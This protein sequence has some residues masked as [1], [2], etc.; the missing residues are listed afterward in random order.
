[1]VTV[2]FILKRLLNRT[3]TQLKRIACSRIVQIKRTKENIPLTW[4]I[5]HFSPKADHWSLLHRAN[6]TS[7][8]PIGHPMTHVY[9]VGCVQQSNSCLSAWSAMF[10]ITRTCVA[11]N[12]SL[13]SNQITT[14]RLVSC[15]AWW[16]MHQ[17]WLKGCRKKAL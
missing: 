3:K 17:Q 2:G 9:A 13:T 1:M 5:G 14:W 11:T 6:R 4:A 12:W 8:V 7:L 15:S 16:L 10:N